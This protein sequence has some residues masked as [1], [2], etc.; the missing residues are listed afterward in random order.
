MRSGSEAALAAARERWDALLYERGNEAAFA[1]EIFDLADTLGSS[2]A[3]ARSLTDASRSGDDRVQLARDVL[4]GKVSGEVLDL[5]CG[6]VR[7][8]WSDDDDL[9]TSL[10]E[11]GILSVL[12]GAQREGRLVRVEEELYRC[13]RVLRDERDVRV[14]LS[15]PVFPKARRVELARQVFAAVAPET[16]TLLGRAVSYAPQPS[17]AQ[18]LLRMM[19]QAATRNHHLVAAVTAAAPLTTEQEERL[20]RI[21]SARYGQEVSVHV[22]VEPAVVG[23][24]RI[25]VGDEVID[26]SL[27]TRIKHVRE[28]I[29]K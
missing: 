21:L 22:A 29:V 20:T 18:S 25:R 19:N 1:T 10:E 28:E 13:M 15:E 3:L 16:A 4:A 14:V 12:A 7:E 8:H 23:G 9:L 2:L 17:L 11:L 6:L 24:L 5:L 27:A 26:G